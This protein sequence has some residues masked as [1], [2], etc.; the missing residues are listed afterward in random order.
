MKNIE[1]Y[2]KSIRLVFDEI[3]NW[4]RPKPPFR[5][6]LVDLL[7]GVSIFFF[8]FSLIPLIPLGLSFLAESTNYNIGKISLSNITIGSFG[9]IWLITAVIS[10]LIMLL[11]VWIND[12]VDSIRKDSTRPPHS[13]SPEQLSFIAIYEAYEE[14]KIFF[15]SHVEKHIENSY[16]ALTSVMDFYPE[17]DE[18]DRW[19]GQN[20]IL[21]DQVGSINSRYYPEYRS[22][23][24]S[25][26]S[27]ETQVEAAT[28]FLKTFEKYAW[29]Q[30]DENTKS[31]LQALI[32]FSQKIP[33]RLRD[34]EDLPNVLGI[35]ENFS[36]FIY[37]YLPE[38]KT[39][40]EAEELEKLQAVGAECLIKFSK[41]MNNLTS[42]TRPKKDKD[43]K[44][45]I[46]PKLKE[47]LQ[48]KFNDNIFI[49][50]SIWFILISALTTGAVL[51]INFRIALS[52]DTMV[53]LIIGTSVASAAALTGIL[54]RKNQ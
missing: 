15:V 32:S 18:D 35:I 53:M 1:I 24:S 48:E 54:P 44:V 27:L 25:R 22:Y 21:E 14:L 36:R 10:L 4:E 29:F 17:F 2:Y 43:S 33:G 13:L 20:D 12:K 47:K 23:L 39:Y 5:E 34:K 31:I 38:H 52:S 11:F 28:I 42:Y 3:N 45:D 7:L 16:Q 49:R 41:E 6:K 46:P 51:L 9:L 19:V 40:M 30:L 26:A 37:A 50:F 8:V